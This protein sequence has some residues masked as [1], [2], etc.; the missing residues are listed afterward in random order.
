MGLLSSWGFGILHIAL[1]TIIVALVGEF[2][3]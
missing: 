2:E 3:G 1:V